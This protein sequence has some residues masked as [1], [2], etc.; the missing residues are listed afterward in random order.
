MPATLNQ[1]F[2]PLHKLYISRDLDNTKILSYKL[3]VKPACVNAAFASYSKFTR[4]FD[5]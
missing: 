4:Q 3:V 1:A 2:Y 5:K